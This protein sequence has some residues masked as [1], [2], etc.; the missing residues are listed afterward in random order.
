MLNLKILL[1]TLACS[2]GKCTCFS[3]TKT[4]NNYGPFVVTIKSW[5]SCKGPKAINMTTVLFELNEKNPFLI[6]Y[7]IT[8]DV[9]VRLSEM[10][11]QVWHIEDLQKNKLWNYKIDKPCQHYALA[12][13]ISS[14]LSLQQN[15]IVKKVCEPFC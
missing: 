7:N 13:L 12:H 4:A 14:Y 8:F 1:L 2:L 15:C 9:T 5:A 10:K 3:L 6:K 11:V